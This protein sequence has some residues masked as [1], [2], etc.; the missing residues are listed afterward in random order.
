M[1]EDLFKVPEVQFC[2]AQQ[3]CQLEGKGIYSKELDIKSK[4]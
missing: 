1:R 4:K 2:P 3:M